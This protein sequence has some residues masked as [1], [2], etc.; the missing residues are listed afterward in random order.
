MWRAFLSEPELSP[1]KKQ[2]FLCLIVRIYKNLLAT[3]KEATAADDA[4]TNKRS[5]TVPEKTFS[6]PCQQQIGEKNG[7][8]IYLLTFGTAPVVARLR[9]HPRRDH[10]ERGGQRLPRRGGVGLPRL[11]AGGGRRGGPPGDKGG[12]KKAF[13]HSFPQKKVNCVAQVYLF[14]SWS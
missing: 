12:R 10:P 11:G 2:E 9:R 5:S 13:M 14:R 1:S 6:P 4:F 3:D 8:F 7:Q